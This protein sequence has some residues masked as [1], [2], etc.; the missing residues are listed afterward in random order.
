MRVK[1]YET[2]KIPR[3]LRFPKMLP[4]QGFRNQVCSNI[5]K[6]AKSNEAPVFKWSDRC[7]RD[8]DASKLKDAGNS[9]VGSNSGSS[10]VGTGERNSLFHGFPI[11]AGESLEKGS[12]AKR[13]GTLVACSCKV[14]T[15]SKQRHLFD[16]APL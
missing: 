16:S 1:A 5:T 12:P 15:R 2:F 11:L 10:V 6:L 14:Q 8:D 9:F 4:N 7:H 13:S 3:F